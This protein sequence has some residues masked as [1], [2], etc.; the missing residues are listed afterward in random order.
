MTIVDPKYS[1]N[2][3]ICP[4]YESLW[5]AYVALN[6]LLIMLLSN[7]RLYDLLTSIDI[8]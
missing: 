8:K 7:H 1:F 5:L 2:V 4:Q 6:A 3:Q